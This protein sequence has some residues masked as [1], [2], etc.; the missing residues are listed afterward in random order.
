LGTPFNRSCLVSWVLCKFKVWNVWRLIL[1]K[2]IYNFFICS[3]ITEHPKFH[4]TPFE[5]HCCVVWITITNN[6]VLHIS[7]LI[8]I[9]VPKFK[10][11]YTNGERIFKKHLSA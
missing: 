10:F 7:I 2:I 5:N 4:G 1:N 8:Q 9:E 3:N 11:K 6:R